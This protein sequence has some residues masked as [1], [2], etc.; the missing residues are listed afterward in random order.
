MII[1]Y[2]LVQHDKHI[3][4]D[5]SLGVTTTHILTGPQVPDISLKSFLRV[6]D[7]KILKASSK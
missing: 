7:Y 4:I 6:V 2:N 5:R 3:E 1:A